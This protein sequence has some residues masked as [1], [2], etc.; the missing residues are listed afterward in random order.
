MKYKYLILPAVLL[1]ILALSYNSTAR[2]A[3]DYQKCKYWDNG[4]V[5]TRNYYRGNGTLEQRIK[6]NKHG[7]KIEECYYD[8][9][10]NLR[11]GI[12]GWAAMKWK[13]KDDNLIRENYYGDDGHLKERKI[14]NEYGDLVA[15]QYVGDGSI[16]PSEEF[17]PIPPVMGEEDV[18]YFGKEGEPEGKTSVIRY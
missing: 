3:E 7:R 2:A 13:Y 8:E 17:N 15:K 9:N 4:R 12:D 14:Y 18:E 6:Y 11:Q 5:K 16:D 10:G 1:G